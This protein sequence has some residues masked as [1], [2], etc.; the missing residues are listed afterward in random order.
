MKLSKIFPEPDDLLALQPEELAE[1][2]LSV[3]KTAD[4]HPGSGNGSPQNNTISAPNFFNTSDYFTNPPEY[5]SRQPEINAALME[6]WQWLAGAGLLA[7]CLEKRNGSFF[8]TRAGRAIKTKEDFSTFRKG[9]L[10]R[11]NLLHATIA[12]KVYPAFLRGEYDSAIFLAFREVEITVRKTSNLDSNLTGVPLMR[13]AFGLQGTLSD[14]AVPKGENEAM[15]HLFAGAFGV[16]RNAVSH[17]HVP[18]DAA[19]TSEIIGLASQLLRIVDRLAHQN[20]TASL[21]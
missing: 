9:L 2:L 3:L 20:K 13:E 19:E 12:N 1:P 11:R 18:T 8:I 21:Q 17:R 6:A 14:P 4:R 5:G 7:E 16:F 15:A 10:L